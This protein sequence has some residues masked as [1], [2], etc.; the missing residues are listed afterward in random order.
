MYLGLVVFMLKDLFFTSQM[1]PVLSLLSHVN[2]TSA[3]NT[4][5]GHSHSL[6][7]QENV[8]NFE[9]T[10]IFIQLSLLFHF[11]CITHC[12]IIELL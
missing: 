4:G 6:R 1:Y 5:K 10:Y 2:P 9:P 11:A 8:H 12:V 7:P 3:Q